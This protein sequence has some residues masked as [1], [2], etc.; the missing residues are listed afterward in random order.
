MALLERG[1]RGVILTPAGRALA[2]HARLVLHQIE[3]MKGELS[4]YAGGIKGRIRMQANASAFS[5]FLPSALSAFLADNPRIDVDRGKLQLSNRQIRSGR[6]RR[7]RHRCRYCGVRRSRVTSLRD[8]PAR[9]NHAAR[10]S[11]RQ[12]A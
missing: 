4:E 3:H 5:E 8:R 2:H 6:I 7:G 9:S 12:P 10:S 11:R 1:Q